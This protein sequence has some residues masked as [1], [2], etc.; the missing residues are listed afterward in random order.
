MSRIRY[1]QSGYNGFSRSVR[2]TQAEAEGKFP[3]TTAAKELG[4]SVKAFT[5]G[6]DRAG[7]SACEWHHVS[8]YANAVDFY[9]TH[10][11]RASAAFWVGAGQAYKAKANRAECAR[12]ARQCRAEDRAESLRLKR[13]DFARQL[14]RQ[15]QARPASTRTGSYELFERWLSALLDAHGLLS[16]SKVAVSPYGH[17]FRHACLRHFPRTHDRAAL[18]AFAK[19][20][21]K[22][23]LR[24]YRNYKRSL[25]KMAETRRRDERKNAARLR[26]AAWIRRTAQMPDRHTHLVTADACLF[27]GPVAHPEFALHRRNGSYNQLGQRTHTFTTAQA[28]AW[29]REHCLLRSPAVVA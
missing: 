9:D 15:M 10:E 2:A 22:E 6:C 17:T 8:K 4:L 3:K 21:A 19:D 12:L 18:I 1:G 20:R 29:F 14:K 7:I 5:A 16:I 24:N 23:Q 13:A 26:L 25:A 27:L 11:C 28:A